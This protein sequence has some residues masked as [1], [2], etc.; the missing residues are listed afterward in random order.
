MTDYVVYFALIALSS[1]CYVLYYKQYVFMPKMQKLNLANDFRYARRQNAEL[2]DL[3]CLNSDILQNTGNVFNGLTFE[4]ALTNLQNLDNNFYTTATYKQMTGKQKTNTGYAATLQA[5]V[6][7]Q[8]KIQ[9]ELKA[10]FNK[11]MLN[12]HRFIAA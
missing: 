5:D 7:R 10:N 12:Y 6:A 11:L 1:I 2:I 3:F 4:A 9:H 8:I